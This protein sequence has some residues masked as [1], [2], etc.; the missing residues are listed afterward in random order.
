M[1]IDPDLRDQSGI[2]EAL[3]QIL[4]AMERAE[5]D[6]GQP[7]FCRNRGRTAA[8]G[9]EQARGE[10][11][12]AGVQMSQTDLFPQSTER[13]E[14]VPP[15]MTID[16]DAVPVRQVRVVREDR[17]LVSLELESLGKIAQ[18]PPWLQVHLRLR[19]CFGDYRNP[20]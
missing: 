16:A 13:A 7:A 2:E 18:V 6:P 17:G 14:I 5:E 1:S 15:R 12:D 11:K 20:K 4:P 19:E 3:G 9:E 8:R 10:P